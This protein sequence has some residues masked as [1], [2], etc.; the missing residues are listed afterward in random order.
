MT[1][2]D[3]YVYKLVKTPAPEQLTLGL[4]LAHP[5]PSDDLAP[6]RDLLHCSIVIWPF[7]IAPFIFKTDLSL[8]R[9]INQIHE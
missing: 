8:V 7:P 3:D 5:C 9:P 6:T 2:G 1:R 4:S